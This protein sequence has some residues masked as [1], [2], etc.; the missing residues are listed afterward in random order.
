MN[1][2]HWECARQATMAARRHT[3]GPGHHLAQVLTSGTMMWSPG[4][5]IIIGLEANLLDTPPGTKI[6]TAWTHHARPLLDRAPFATR[7]RDDWTWLASVRWGRTGERLNPWA[8]DDPDR[9]YRSAEIA[10]TGDIVGSMLHRIDET[11]RLSFAHAA[12]C[13][14]AASPVVKYRRSSDMRLV[15]FSADDIGFVVIDLGPI[16]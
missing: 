1:R 3:D 7:V 14:F 11:G 16:R 8:L 5:G 4:V 6:I 13:L 12:G 9:R 2:T 15:W 10:D